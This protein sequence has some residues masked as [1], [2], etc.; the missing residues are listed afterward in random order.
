MCLIWKLSCYAFGY[1]GFAIALDSINSTAAIPSLADCYAG[2]E[3]ETANIFRKMVSLPSVNWEEAKMKYDK[4]VQ[5]GTT[6]PK[7]QKSL[8]DY[9]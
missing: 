1:A 6:I 8:S 3:P 4:L 7:E 9:L 2:F 5:T